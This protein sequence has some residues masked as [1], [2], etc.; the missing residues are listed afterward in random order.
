M[1]DREPKIVHVITDL[2]IGGAEMALMRLVSNSLPN[3]MRHHVVSLKRGG[4]LEDEIRAKGVP[5]TAIGLQGPRDFAS[6][7]FRLATLFRTERPDLIVTWLYHADLLGTLAN[8]LAVRAPLM[9]NI[10]CADMDLSKYS[11]LTRALPRI[12]AKLSRR[13]SAIVT[14]S[15]AG[16][17]VHEAYGYRA[18]YWLT[19]PNGFDLS[20][21]RPDSRAR[22]RMR[23]ELGVGPETLLVG[24]IARV[25]PMKG[26]DTFLAAA[27]QVASAIPA[28]RFLL[29]G[30]GTDSQEFRETVRAMGLSA[31]KFLLL[32]ERRDMPSILSALDLNVSSSRTEGFSNTIAEAMAVEV[33]CVVTDVGDSAIIVGDT[34][35]I[36]PKESPGDLAEAMIEILR[37]SGPERGALGT[38]ARNRI[39]A[40]FG[41]EA[42]GQEYAKTFV[43]VIRGEIP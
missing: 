23:E 32:G 18:R 13:A 41:A 28:A 15:N 37:L 26:H 17:R 20:T 22:A 1:T 40:N 27:T 43:G 4:I 5:V 31:E 9:W 3:S 38:A 25:D 42:I 19:I 36:V 39:A 30:R 29:V 33:P 10:R 35:R 24:L 14:N 7:I 34:G 6:A 8:S 16:R 2:D 11:A 21:F 12:L